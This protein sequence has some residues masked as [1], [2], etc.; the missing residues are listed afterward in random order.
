MK[1][2]VVANSRCG[3]YWILRMFFSQLHKRTVSLVVDDGA[4]FNPAN[5]V[6]PGFYFEEAVPVLEDFERLTIHDLGHAIGNG[7]YAVMDVHLACGDVN[8]VVRFMVKT[9]AP[10]RQCK[11]PE[12]EQ[13]KAGGREAAGGRDEEDLRSR[14]HSQWRSS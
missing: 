14:T 4:L 9:L 12:Q 8:G 7:G 1:I 13:R 3:D 5:L 10:A 6:L 11:Q 2:D